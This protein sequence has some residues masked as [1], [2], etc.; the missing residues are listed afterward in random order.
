MSPAPLTLMVARR[1]SRGRY[2]DFTAWLEE[3]RALAADF[4]GYLGSGVLAPPPGDDEY[5]II[6]RFR[7]ADTLAAWEHSASRRAWLARGE[8]LFVAPQ[9]HRATGLDGW[10]QDATGQTPPRWKQAIA[11][12]LA[13]FPV[14]LLFQA[15][16]SGLLAGLPMLPKVL[17]STLALT[18]VMVFL[19]IPLS[20]R[21]LGPWLRG[22]VS[23]LARLTRRM[24]QRG[25]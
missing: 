15:L 2:A 6:F 23:I 18:P 7:D 13:F 5:Q 8:G 22:E 14:S 20:M 3:G 12:W 25:A 19:F 16:F 11:I 1:V 24:H 17:V 4:S 10:F 9:E 21:L